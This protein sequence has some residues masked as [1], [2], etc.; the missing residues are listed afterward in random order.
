MIKLIDINDII[1]L[2][3][4]SLNTD[5]GKKLTFCIE[6][7]QKY[8]VTPFLGDSLYI[9]MELDF[10][11]GSP[12]FGT[13]KYSKLFNGCDYIYSQQ[14]FRHGGIKSMLI[15][16]SYARYLQNSKVNPTA[17]G[18]VEKIGE[19]STGV[20]EKTL[21]R[22]VSNVIALAQAEQQ[23]VEMFLRYNLDYPEWV[24]ANK[25]L[26]K[27]ATGIKINAIGGD[28]RNAVGSSYK[29]NRCGRY[30]CACKYF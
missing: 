22:Q 15:Y 1:T 16:Y 5:V 23:K 25:Y 24:Y 12:E 26:T 11:T 10:S 13:L 2:K 28:K 3:P 18:L 7:A 21:A 30:R 4:M 6:E 29:C 9:L 19:H 20:D 8:D 17:F 14:T 27:S